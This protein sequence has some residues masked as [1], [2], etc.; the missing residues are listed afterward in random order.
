MKVYFTCSTAQFKKYE[1]IYFVIRDFLVS[2]NHTLTRDWL[3]SAKKRIE[4]NQIDFEDIQEIYNGCIKAIQE[5]DVVIVEDTV[6]NFST[7]HQITVALQRRKPVLVLWQKQKEKK[8]KKMFIHG[9]QS[10]FLVVKEY[11]KKNL[12]E[13][14]TEFLSKY[15]D[16]Q[17]TNRFHLVLQKVERDY[18][19][20]AQYNKH[21]SRTKL[22]REAIR[23][24][25]DEDSDYKKYLSKN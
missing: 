21:K 10:D 12:K 9:V 18:L 6:S 23:K 19:D 8:F 22:I 20:W 13:E 5:A 24:V 11:D 3:Q 4:V 1:S 17:E 25:L 15:E 14:L 2:Q 16:A 7:G